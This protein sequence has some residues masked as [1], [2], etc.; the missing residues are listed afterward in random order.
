MK[1]VKLEAHGFKSFADPVVLRF[2]GGVAGIVGPNGSGKSNINDAIRWV[3]GEQSSKELRGDSM[4]DVI[5]A[6]SKTVQPMNKASVSLTFDNKDRL[7]SIDSDFITITRVLERGKGINDYFINGEKSRH[8]DIKTIAMETGIGKSSLAIISQGTVADI[9]QSSDDERRSI[10]EEAAGVSKYKFRKAESVKKLQLADQSLNVIEATVSELEKRLSTLKKQAEKAYLYKEKSEALKNIEIGFLAY[11]IEQNSQIKNQL[12]QELEGVEETREQF[13]KTIQELKEKSAEKREK[14]KELSAELADLRGKAE[15]IK[16]RVANLNSSILEAKT[17]RKMIAEGHAIDEKAK[18]ES[19]IGEIRSLESAVT[20]LRE[21][22][23]KYKEKLNVSNEKINNLQ[24]SINENYINL[25]KINEQIRTNDINLNLLTEKQRNH[26]NLF[27]GVKTIIENKQLFK[28]FKGIVGQLIKVSNEHVLALETILKS[29]A[30]HIVVDNSETAVKAIEFLKKN[31]SGRATFIPLSSIQPKFIRDDYLLIVRNQPGFVGVASD[32]VECEP[33]YKKLVDFLIGNVLVTNDIQSANKISSIIEKK[34]MIVTQDGNIIRVGGIMVGGSAESSD[35][36]IGI[37]SRIEE[38]KKI[39]PGLKAMQNGLQQTINKLSA[40][41]EDEKKYNQNYSVEYK[42]LQIQ[43]ENNIE[44]INKYKTEVQVTN[45]QIQNQGIDNTTISEQEILELERD[46]ISVNFDL[47]TKTEIKN[48]LDQD[49]YVIGENINKQNTM[50]AQLLNSYNKKTVTLNKAMTVLEL[51]QKRLSIDYGLTLDFA[52]KNFK[53]ETSAQVAEE[54]VNQLRVEIAELG[55]VNLDS[56]R[57]CEEVEER[58]NFNVSNRD[59][60]LEAKNICLSA[61]AEL[62]KKIVTRLTNIVNDVN[63]EMHKVFSSMFGG[64]SAEVKFVN[65]N[66]V[67]ESGISIYAQPPGK[68]VKNLKLFSGGEK[69]LIAISLLFAILRAR[70]LPL[71]ILDEVE[72]AL[73]EANVVRFAEYLQE[74]KHQTQFL[75]ITHRVGTMTRVDALFGATMQKRGVT[76]FF[77]VQLEEA[78]KL[79]DEAN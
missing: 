23:N 24:I 77:S 45:E 6:G 19:V 54:T 53:L 61:I 9:A 21:S 70:P 44:K 16:Q 50:L 64:G 63:Q 27:K 58:Y 52:K 56:I 46:L 8:K 57:E 15:A 74:L 47:K 2:D 42:N 5:F 43:I 78:K 7:S 69:S 38:L 33:E 48:D 13:E 31:N 32:L 10:F 28:G 68:S 22:L 55:S 20:Y 25:N 17:R 30:Q 39:I 18:L 71:C 4:E 29:A 3:L 79:V 12:S 11:R 40:E 60:L 65:P 51:D 75:V 66:N 49:I 1:L 41:I 14:S 26:T 36:I 35:D 67:L 76:N 59:E 72:A 34:Y 62:D 37:D 73:D